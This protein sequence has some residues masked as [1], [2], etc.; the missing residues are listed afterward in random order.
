MIE[1]A[2]L[3]LHRVLSKI[4]SV[5]FHCPVSGQTDGSESAAHVGWTPVAENENEP[6]AAKLRNLC[7]PLILTHRF[8]AVLFSRMRDVS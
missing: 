2:S 1:R 6:F 7:T 5:V 3:T 4:Y 8:N